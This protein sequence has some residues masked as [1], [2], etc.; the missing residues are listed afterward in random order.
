MSTAVYSLEGHEKAS[1]KISGDALTTNVSGIAQFPGEI[2]L[3]DDKDVDVSA[4]ELSHKLGTAHPRCLGGTL[5][6][7]RAL[8]IPMNRRSDPNLAWYFVW[9]F[10]KRSEET[11]GKH[12]LDAS[13][14]AS[15]VSTNVDGLSR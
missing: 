9:R 4:R 14:V 7:Y 1:R 11:V 10:A 8:L 5:H 15:P 6:R 2:L 3:I 13:H 12:D